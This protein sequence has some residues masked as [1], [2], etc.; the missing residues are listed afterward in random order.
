MVEVDPVGLAAAGDAFTGHAARLSGLDGF[1]SAAFAAAAQ[2]SGHPAVADAATTAGT[3]WSGV[4]TRLRDTVDTL[5]GN[6]RAA[7]T[8]Y[9][10]VDRVVG[11]RMTQSVHKQDRHG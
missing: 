4:G 2:A 5:G 9:D 7:A 11:E 1:L 6:A 8:V 3:H 10:T